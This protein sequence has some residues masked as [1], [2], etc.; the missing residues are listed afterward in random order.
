MK[1]KMLHI[2]RMVYDELLP[3][4][5]V[6]E[7][8]GLDFLLD[9]TFNL[10]FLEANKSPAM[11]ATT[12][13]KGTIQKRMIKDLLEIEY[14]LLENKD[15]DYAINITLFQYVYNGFKPPSDRFYGI[16]SQDCIF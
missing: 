11:M 2:V 4:P 15:L 14:A 1:K 3:H 13:T 10:W 5:G 12:E 9:D 7:I 6:F 16:L 8:F